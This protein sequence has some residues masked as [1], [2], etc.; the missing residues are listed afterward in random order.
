[1][2]LR[3]RKRI[4]LIGGTGTIGRATLGSLSEQGH[5]IVCFVRKQD[6]AASNVKTGVEF[7]FGNV[8]D[9][10]SVSQ[11]GL[12]DET[13]DAMI[14]TLASRTGVSRDAWAIDY[15][16]H[17][18]ILKLAQSHQIPQ[19]ILLSALC[20]QKPRLPFQKAKLAFENELIASGLTYSIIRPTAFFKSLSGQIKRVRNGKPFLIFGD[21]RLTS[22]KP[23]SDKDLG[24]FIASCLNDPAQWNKIL[25]IGGPGKAITPREQGEII[26]ALLGQKPRFQSVPIGLLKTIRQVLLGL[27]HLNQKLADKAELASIGLYYATESMLVWNPTTQHYEEDA[28]PS[29]G[30]ETLQ[31]YY[32]RL[33]NNEATDDRGDHAIF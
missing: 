26:F 28:T 20:V 15:Q 14:S 6:P 27:G 31:A 9:P 29:T 19:F 10:S 24:D 13:F 32:Q 16:A 2:P 7:R 30:H 17:S 22:C 18:D 4:F 23:I 33:L 11:A 21:G 12:R 5:D 1:M 25:P 8:L 3:T